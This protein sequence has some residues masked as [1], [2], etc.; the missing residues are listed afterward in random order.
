MYVSRCKLQ[1]RPSHIKSDRGKNYCVEVKLEADV[2]VK[3][4]CVYSGSGGH[5][6]FYP[7]IEEEG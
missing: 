5:N 3:W 1:D 4:P 6:G 2:D 7:F